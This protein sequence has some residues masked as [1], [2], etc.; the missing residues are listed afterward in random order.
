MSMVR[1]DAFDESEF[2]RILERSG[3]RV[4]LIGRRALIALGL[5]LLTADYDLWIH[6]D[7]I[8]TLNRAVES[9]E[10]VPNRSPSEARAGGRYVLENGE[11]VD[12][13][14]ARSVPTKDGVRVTFDDVWSRRE[15]LIYE[16][17]VKL[18]IPAIDD[19]ILT[20]RWSMRDKDVSD[21]RLLEQ[22]KRAKGEPDV[23]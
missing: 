16:P 3:A 19:L 4:L 2:F 22:L 5:P 18:A 21:I 1:A 23:T 20:K 15:E 6:I 14:V 8:E 11:H 9:L 12:V 17:N 10:L 7:D 13:L